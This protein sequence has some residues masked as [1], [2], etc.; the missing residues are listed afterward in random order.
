MPSHAAPLSSRDGRVRSSSI[1]DQRE[2]YYYTNEDVELLDSIVSLGQ[3]LLPT[4][5]KREQLPT[6]AL[7]RAADIVFPQYGISPDGEDKYSRVIFL[8]GGMRTTDDLYERF[9]TVLERM[10]IVIE[11]VDG[12]EAAAALPIPLP[13]TSTDPKPVPGLVRRHSDGTTASQQ[14]RR[15]SDSPARPRGRVT[16]ADELQELPIP[17]PPTAMA[18]RPMDLWPSHVEADVESVDDDDDDDDDAGDDADNADNV[19]DADEDSDDEQGDGVDKVDQYTRSLEMVLGL[20]AAKYEKDR[21]GKEYKHEHEQVYNLPIRPRNEAATAAE[22]LPGASDTLIH[23][24][25]DAGPPAK[26]DVRIMARVADTFYLRFAFLGGQAIEKWRAASMQ[27]VEREQY[28]VRMDREL[29]LSEAVIVWGGAVEGEV[30]GEDEVESEAKGED[31]DEDE[32]EEDDEEDETGLQVLEYRDKMLKLAGRAYDI[33]LVYKAFT[34]WQV[35]ALEEEERTQVARRH[36]LRKKVFVG[37]RTQTMQDEATVRSLVL[38]WAVVRW[39]TCLADIWEQQMTAEGVDERELTVVGVWTWL[40]AYQ[41]R[42]AE[43]IRQRHEQ[44]LKTAAARQWQAIWGQK[45]ARRTQSAHWT[46]LRLVGAA[47]DHWVEQAQTQAAIRLRIEAEE[48]LTFARAA[49]QDLQKQARLARELR[50]MQAA[51][52]AE[53]KLTSVA[54]WW[55]RTVAADEEVASQDRRLLRDW[56]LLW[57]REVR[58]VQFRADMVH[59]AKVDAVHSWMLAEKV[60]FLGRYRDGRLLRRAFG[61]MAEVAGV[62]GRRRRWNEWEAQRDAADELRQAN[63]LW[64]SSRQATARLQHQ[65]AQEARADALLCRSRAASALGRL[66]SAAAASAWRDSQLASMAARG[67]YYVAVTDALS[68]WAQLARQT[69][70]ARLRATYRAFRLTI[71]RETARSCVAVWLQQKTSQNERQTSLLAT[72]VTAADTRMC[73]AAVDAWIAAANDGLFRQAVAIEADAEAY[74]SRWR[75][76]LADQTTITDAAAEHH[77]VSVLLARWDGWELQAVQARARRHTAAALREKNER[78]L[79]RRVVAGWQDWMAEEAEAEDDEVEDEADEADEDEDEAQDENTTIHWSSTSFPSSS[80][81]RL[82]SSSLRSSAATNATNATTVT[83][84]PFRPASSFLLHPIMEADLRSSQ[85]QMAAQTPTRHRLLRLTPAPGRTL[86]PTPKPTLGAGAGTGPAP[87][88]APTPARL[89][90][91]LLSAARLADSVQLGPMSAFDEDEDDE[92][93][94]RNGHGHLDDDADASSDADDLLLLQSGSHARHRLGRS[95]TA[96]SAT[97][98]RRGPPQPPS[99][100][101]HAS[102]N[103]NATTTPMAPLP[104]PFERRLRAAYRS[105]WA[106]GN[107]RRTLATTTTPLPSRRSAAVTFADDYRG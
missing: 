65:R 11:Y 57:M 93:D 26:V 102:A 104:S 95:Y 1:Q 29:S 3:E 14:H 6:T 40:R 21:Q 69:R 103:T 88:P 99:G 47:V 105:S 86:K 24:E 10:G 61:L 74:L 44:Q 66:A 45:T 60:V 85:M 90:R 23:E 67:A 91:R 25:L 49:L 106:P 13:T 46:R 77:I 20:P 37:W 87:I 58:L 63:L 56:A 30:E 50:R 55:Q 19:D 73:F 92:H 101:V 36:V 97:N 96:A 64:T 5:P 35:M 72:A 68:G 33:S 22:E 107:G 76:R 2:P 59:D 100:S 79:V 80:A 82:G 12:D 8:I 98:P 17:R 18:I 89:R 51:R 52:R 75:L 70:E 16:F 9:R 43:A 7:F 83:A 78:R 38:G 53:L 54:A 62:G 27:S 4:L 28:A 48:D 42:V 94:S 31:E 84:T 39:R 71:K 32:D 34:H 15:R 81:W 41:E